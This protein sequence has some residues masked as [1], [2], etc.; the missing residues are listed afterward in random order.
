MCDG[1]TPL[2]LH[3]WRVGDLLKKHGFD[4][5]IYLAGLLHDIVEDSQTTLDELY[6]L[7]YSRRT[8]SLVDFVTHD[9]TMD[10]AQQQRD[11][12]IAKLIDARNA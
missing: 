12:L 2:Y 6:G 9:I 3:S 11:G 10:D 5:E 7:G 8:V 1:V 4:E